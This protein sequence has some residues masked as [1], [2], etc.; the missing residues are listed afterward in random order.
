MI[1]LE[2]YKILKTSE[3]DLPL[4]ISFQINDGEFITIEGHS[5]AG[6]TTVLRLI[7]GLVKP[8]RGSLVVNGMEWLDTGKNFYLPPQKRNVGFVFQEYSL[9][10]N[11]TVYENIRYALNGKSGLSQV[12]EA[13][14]IMELEQLKDRYPLNLSG[15]Q[16]QRAA[17]ARA[18][19]R[20]PEILLLDEPLSAL[21]SEMRTRL[22]DYI[23]KV[24]RLLKL[25]TIMVSHDI[26]EIFKMSDR[27]I[28]LDKGKIINEGAAQEVF[29]KKYISGKFKFTGQCVHIFTLVYSRT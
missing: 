7:A 15:G 28:R 9:F 26:S 13:M 19:V 25:T 27:V 14:E 18:I 1:S 29:H 8:E 4:D 21:D 5:G 16:K 2:L 23:L 12:E 3:G 11:M 6:K 17:L 20:K 24:H 22:Q 10:P